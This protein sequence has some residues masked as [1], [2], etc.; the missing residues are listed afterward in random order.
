M[1]KSFQFCNVIDFQ[2]AFH[3]KLGEQNIKTVTKIIKKE[4]N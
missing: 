4:K 3:E 2:P 1:P